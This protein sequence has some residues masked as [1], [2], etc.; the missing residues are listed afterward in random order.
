VHTWDLA[1]ALGRSTADL[2]P[3]VADRGLAFVRATM[4]DDNRSLAFGLEQPA[5]DDADAYKRVAAVAGRSVRRRADCAELGGPAT[6]VDRRA[7]PH[8]LWSL[9]PGLVTGE[10]HARTG[11]TS[12]S[13]TCS[14]ARLARPTSRGMAV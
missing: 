11:P 9:L 8:G 1:T 3:E 13:S 5:P 12:L 2:D 4:T 6:A 7:A 10:V 14:T